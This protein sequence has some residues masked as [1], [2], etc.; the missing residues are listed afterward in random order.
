MYMVQT[1]QTFFSVSVLGAKVVSQ[2]SNIEISKRIIMPTRIDFIVSELWIL[3]WNASVQRAQLFAKETTESRR[4]EFRSDIVSYLQNDIIPKYETDISEEQHI[5]NILKLSNLGTIK[6]KNILGPA[7]YKIGVAQKLLNLQLK[8]L[9]CLGTI[10]EPPHCPVDRI[11]INETD[12]KDQISWTKITGID[13]YLQVITVLKRAAKLEGLSLTRW[14]LEI[15]SR[16]RNTENLT[17]AVKPFPQKKKDEAYPFKSHG[18]GHR[19]KVDFNPESRLLKFSYPTK[20]NGN[21]RSPDVFTF[22]EIK[23][24]C[25]YLERKFKGAAFPLANN[26]DRLGKRTEKPGLG[27][28]IRTLPESVTKAQA[29]SYLGPYFEKVGLFQ[30]V[31]RRPATWILI[32]SPQNV[33]ETILNFY[34]LA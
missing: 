30:I 24:I 5:E 12:L 1:G 33:K 6:G 19:F 16:R 3:S 14:E 15:Y 26:V 34:N 8:Y 13:E 2:V 23:K 25:M 9:W 10:S 20:P 31:N 7:G 22:D 27:M 21:Q 18:K 32:S 11:I 4:R 28:A 17:G 29:S